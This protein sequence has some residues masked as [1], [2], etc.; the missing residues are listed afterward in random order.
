MHGADPIQR[1]NV[2]IVT[3]LK[4]KLGPWIGRY[5]A[6]DVWPQGVISFTFDDFPKSAFVAGA[7]ILER[8]G[9]R[10][11]Y[12][13][14]AGLAGTEGELGRQF[15]P[16]DVVTLHDRG[17]EIACHTHS[18]LRCSEAR[19]SA[20]RKEI[21]ANRAVLSSFL[22]RFRPANFAYPFGATSPAAHRAVK[23]YFA[24]CRG[25]RPGINEGVLYVRELLANKLYASNFDEG[26]IRQL[27]DRN[28]KVGGW[29]IFYTHDVDDAPSPYGCTARQL[30]SV[31]AYAAK[32]QSV[33]T[34]REVMA[35]LRERRW[36]SAGWR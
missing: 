8:H 32:S 25:I 27:I 15:D 13:T 3:R 36:P 1:E 20:I 11:T 17:H 2:D 23:P 28:R 12:Y 9:A 5:R 18:H 6:A 10:G 26:E 4:R 34:V 19:P 22:G 31:V 21:R 16:A 14:A 7:S 29:L 35:S 24:S 33:L 30:E